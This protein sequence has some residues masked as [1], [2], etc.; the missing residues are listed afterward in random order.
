MCFLI[1]FSSCMRRHGFLA[2][3]R[4]K[5][6]SELKS[7]IELACL[8]DIGKINLAPFFAFYRPLLIFPDTEP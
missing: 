4:D 3:L 5:E 7:N 1:F 6:D 2:P 8:V